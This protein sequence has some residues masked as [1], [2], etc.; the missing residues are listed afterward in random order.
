MLSRISLR[1]GVA[2]GVLALCAV[3][4]LRVAR[5]PGALPATAPDTV[6]SAERAMRHVEQIAQR[7]HP[8]GT[9]DHDRVRDYIAG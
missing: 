8:M 7:P 6:F 2:L 3:S 5:P 9:V 1:I 4:I